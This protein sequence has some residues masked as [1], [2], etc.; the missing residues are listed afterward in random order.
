MSDEAVASFRR[1]VLGL[2]LRVWLIAGIVLAIAILAVLVVWTIVAGS[3]IT[4]RDWWSWSGWTSIG[5]L[6]QAAAAIGAVVAAI[7]VIAQ[8][9]ATQ[10]QLGLAR[11]QFQDARR[12]AR[13]ELEPTVTYALWD[14]NDPTATVKIAYL[15]GSDPA[16]DVRFLLMRSINGTVQSVGKRCG[17]LAPGQPTFEEPVK[18]LANDLDWPCRNEPAIQTLE[19]IDFWIGLTWLRSD[20]K[21]VCP[22]PRT[23]TKGAA[24]GRHTLGR[25]GA[26]HRSSVFPGPC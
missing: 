3:F 26:P 6:A 11:Q 22:P 12:Q 14:E 21:R 2:Q 9:R 23:V 1:R 24:V 25:E 15:H 13:A 20:G 4:H 10:N 7:V 19:A 5:S 17:I 18:E 8:L 16:Y